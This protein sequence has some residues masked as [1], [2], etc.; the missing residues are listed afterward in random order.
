MRKKTGIFLM[1][2]IM[3][4]TGCSPVNLSVENLLTAPKLT[5]EQSEIHEA[6][7]SAVGNNITLKYP[8]R[9]ANRSAYVIANIDDEPSDEALVFY[10]YTANGSDEDGLRVN[11][12]DKNDDGKWISVKEIA[13][14][15]VEVDQVIISPMG[16][17]N[18]I[19]V[20]IGYQSIA[21][22]EKTLEIYNYV[23][24]DFKRIGTD[25]Y[26][27]LETYDINADGFNELITIQR[28]SNAETGQ[29]TSKAALLEMEDGEIKK[30]EG[31][32][33]CNNVASYVNSKT[34]K[35]SDNRGAIYI[36]ALTVSGELQTEII[37]YRYS[38]LQNPME[39]RS[40]KLLPL[41]TRPVGYYSVDVDDDGVIEIPT[42]KAM[43]GYENAVED[44]QLF[45]TLWSEYE[46][47]YNLKV[48]YSGYYSISDG[49]SM[50]FPNRWT[51][52]V[53]VKKDSDTGEMV[54]YKYDGNINGN[55]TELMRIAVVSKK[56]SEDYLYEGYELIQSK[57]QLDYFVKLP[58]NKR[59]Q[60]ILT[61]D[62][63]KNNFYL[64]EN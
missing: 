6:L 5:E 10:E 14:A 30:G 33:M 60:L 55:M 2:A 9:G 38:T 34:G 11:I 17:G 7:I 59:E 22:E 42:T 52:Q 53:T 58:T 1:A 39:L 31:I 64:V 24:S 57:G 28:S 19:D 45:M 23:N 48:K 46:D 61:I 35:L 4:M 47:F 13:G 21:G 49:Y 12:L 25:T 26:S 27:V 54:F 15:G 62:E 44:E 20:L 16:H 43:L 41:C 3:S 63:V 40:E 56:F 50:M 32:L 29:V 8:R 36:D 37:Y 18:K 51:D